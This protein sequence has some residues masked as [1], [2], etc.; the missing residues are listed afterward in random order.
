MA[1]VFLYR[2]KGSCSSGI[3]LK[4]PLR[5]CL[6]NYFINYF[7][8]DKK[9][10]VH[11]YWL[12]ST[13]SSLPAIKRARSTVV[14]KWWLKLLSPPLWVLEWLSMKLQMGVGHP[15]GCWQLKLSPLEDQQSLLSFL[16][17]GLDRDGSVIK[18]SEFNSQNWHQVA[19]KQL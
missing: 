2:L 15:F 5:F 18:W 16:I 11:I 1:G 14:F 4:N 9:S 7:L 19:H 8:L 17:M 12:N 13:L 6:D 3:R 10:A